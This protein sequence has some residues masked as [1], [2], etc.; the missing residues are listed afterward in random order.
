MCAKSVV[1]TSQILVSV[2]Y[3]ALFPRERNKE[4][5]DLSRIARSFDAYLRG[6][7]GKVPGIRGVLGQNSFRLAFGQRDEGVYERH[8]FVCVLVCARVSFNEDLK[9]TL[10]FT[11]G[12]VF[13][14]SSKRQ[15][16]NRARAV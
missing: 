1:Y 2:Y 15:K 9:G 11:N 3:S 7:G 13:F 8:R 14:N 16:P 4:R 5:R 12:N 10:F 6:D